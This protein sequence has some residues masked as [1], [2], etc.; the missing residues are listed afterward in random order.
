MEDTIYFVLMG[1][2]DQKSESEGQM[3]EW[4]EIRA[5]PIGVGV[6]DT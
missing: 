2:L 5:G 6:R 4:T 3:E 1:G